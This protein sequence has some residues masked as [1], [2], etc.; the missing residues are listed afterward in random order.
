[1]RESYAHEYA[2]E[3]ILHGSVLHRTRQAAAAN[4]N[5]AALQ[6]AVCRFYASCGAARKI[7]LR[8]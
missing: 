6:F 8:W 7:G 3:I 5:T 2:Y 1:M 4:R